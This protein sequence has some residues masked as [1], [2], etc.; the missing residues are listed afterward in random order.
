[1]YFLIDYLG[2]VYIAGSSFE[3]GNQSERVCD[4]MTR[5]HNHERA[6]DHMILSTNRTKGTPFF[7]S[8]SPLLRLFSSSYSNH[9]H[10]YLLHYGL[11]PTLYY[12]YVYCNIVTSVS[13]IS[14]GV[15]A[16]QI[17]KNINNTRLWYFTINTHF[18][19]NSVVIIF[20]Y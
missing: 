1:M 15:F 13:F 10:P 16:A 3:G 14:V 11:Y 20:P 5:T 6:I 8:V 2:R 19:S 12:L 4:H 9:L 17:R 7:V 18:H